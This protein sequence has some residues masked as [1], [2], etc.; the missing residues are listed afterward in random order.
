MPENPYMPDTDFMEKN[1]DVVGLVKALEHDEYLIRKEAARSLKKVGDERAV[2]S[3]IKSL[4]YENWQ[5][6]H[7]LLTTVREYAAE[8]LSVIGDKR[9]VQPLIN[10]MKEDGV[11]E[12]RWKS[13]WALGKIGDD[14]AVEALNEALNDHYWTVRENAAKALGKIGNQKG[15]EPLIKA[16]NDKEWRVRKY[17][18]LALGDI[19][20]ENAIEPLLNTLNDEDTDVKRK[21]MVALGKMGDAAFGPLMDLFREKDW[22]IRTKAAEVLGDIGDRRAVEPFI[23]VLSKK[24]KEDR[25]RYVRGRVI[26]ALGK[27]GD[28]RAVDVLIPA[29]DDETIFVRQKAEEALHRI[30][31]AKSTV[32]IVHFEDGEISFDYPKNWNISPATD[33]KNL[34]KGNFADNNVILSI[35]KKS[36]A[37][38][39][40]HEEVIEILEDAFIIQNIHIRSK[41]TLKTNELE[42]HMII[43]EKPNVSRTIIMI[44]GFKLHETLY[45]FQFKVR[46]E[47]FEYIRKDIDIIAG[48][49]NTLD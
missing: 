1:K 14:S 25:N 49:F 31:A 22:Y 6:N 38:E 45:F 41:K 7:T 34:V 23:D 15:V 19:G 30:G 42:A 48:S 33:G 24:R 5:S 21:A 47:L 9:A 40:S 11:E 28:P 18:A 35:K 37:G 17:A 29:L 13:A 26:E 27:I 3:L 46:P 43:G 16:L 10:A 8:A 39:I 36:N 4:K 32:D 12:V 2:D 44:I 20:D